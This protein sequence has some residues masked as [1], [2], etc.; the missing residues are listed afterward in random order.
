MTALSP[1]PANLADLAPPAAAPGGDPIR[2]AILAMHPV[3]YHSPLYR[4]I[5]NAPA[6]DGQVLYLDTVGLEGL[7]DKEFDTVVEW[8]IPLLEGHAHE[9]LRNRA[10]NNQGGF[11]S[12][13]NPGLSAALK[14]GRFDAILIQGYSILS[15]WIALLAARRHGIKVVWRGEVTLKPSDTATGPRQRARNAMVRSFLNRCDAVMYTCAGNKDF[16]VH[17]GLREADLFPFLCAVDNDH[18]RAEFAKIAPRAGALRQSLGIPEENLVVLF[19]GRLTQRKRP[20][21]ILEAM[22]RAGPER[23]TFL[24]MGDGPQREELLDFAD[25][26]GIHAVHLGFVNQSQISQYY[27]IADIF[28]LL[29]EYD[30]SPKAL[31][32]AMNFSLVPIVSETVGTSRDLIRPGETGFRVGLGDVDAIAGHLSQLRAD[33]DRRARMA[34]AAQDHVATFSFT[35]NAQGLERACRSA[36]G[37][38][39]TAT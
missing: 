11:F 25:H 24:I 34:Q 26:H 37:T 14:R 38:A 21:D 10:W 15:F 17:H 9:F 6:F 19:C 20:R 30:P 39:E 2:L 12:R 5:C 22:R 33:P 27:T 4:N 32:E 23:L 18:F 8:D 35:A 36:L 3:Q 7:Y 29:S 31:N 13:I 1:M 28:C 16:L